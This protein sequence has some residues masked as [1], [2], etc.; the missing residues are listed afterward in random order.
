MRC[1]FYTVYF[2]SIW[3]L[4]QFR[5]TFISTGFSRSPL[6]TVWT[7]MWINVKFFNQEELKK[8]SIIWKYS[9]RTTR[10]QP[11]WFVFL[12]FY[13]K[14]VFFLLSTSVYLQPYTQAASY[15]TQTACPWNQF[16]VCCIPLWTIYNDCTLSN[17]L[18]ILGLSNITKHPLFILIIYSLIGFSSCCQLAS[19]LCM[20]KMN[21]LHGWE[22]KIILKFSVKKFT[23]AILNLREVLIFLIINNHKNPYIYHERR[24]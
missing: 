9:A 10:W 24:K 16:T 4:D 17:F 7:C 1:I 12:F 2:Q 6:R 15:L 19:C 8:Q 18:Q 11:L 22:V 13:T 14:R 21:L 20:I 23:Q 5:I 3:N